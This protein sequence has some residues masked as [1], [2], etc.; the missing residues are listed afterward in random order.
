MSPESPAD[1]VAALAA[2]LHSILEAIGCTPLE[3]VIDMPSDTLPEVAMKA[4]RAIYEHRFT[5]G[6][7]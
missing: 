2:C 4:R 1:R 3:R 5:R 7:P 6:T